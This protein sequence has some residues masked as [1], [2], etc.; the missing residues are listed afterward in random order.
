MPN[1]L[2]FMGLH[3]VIG[4]CT[5]PSTHFIIVW[6]DEYLFSAFSVYAN[7]LL[8]TYALSFF[9]NLPIPKCSN[10]SLNTRENIRRSRSRRWEEL[11]IRIH[12][13]ESNMHQRIDGSPQL[14]VGVRRILWR[15]PLSSWCEL[16]YRLTRRPPRSIQRDLLAIS[17]HH[18]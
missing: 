11:S 18:L 12:G 7:S 17:R 5:Q 8:V 15:Y 4:K 16:I 2:I 6:I 13:V 3:F 9:T 1:N 10:T 14:E